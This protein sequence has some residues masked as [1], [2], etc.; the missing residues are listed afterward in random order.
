MT[1]VA[2][3]LIKMNKMKDM[4][5]SYE[6]VQGIFSVIEK[7]MAGDRTLVLTL[8]GEESAI[9]NGT[10]TGQRL[11]INEINQN[12][13]DKLRFFLK[14]VIVKGNQVVLDLSVESEIDERAIAVMSLAEGSTIKISLKPTH[15]Y[16]HSIHHLKDHHHGHHMQHHHDGN[17]TD[18]GHFRKNCINGCQC[19]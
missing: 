15:H 3:K 12:E 5:R 4:N 14:D 11:K 2:V 13:S 16:H 17:C 6:K 18:E 9:F 1:F 19:N 8:T 7:K 10:V